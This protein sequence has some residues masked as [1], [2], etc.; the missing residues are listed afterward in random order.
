[1]GVSVVREQ[2]AIITAEGA[3]GGF[4]VTSGR[5]THEAI[6]FAVGKPIVLIDGEQLSK[7][8]ASVS[9]T[10]QPQSH[11][12]FEA[13]RREPAM[14]ATPACPVCKSAMVLRQAKQGSRAGES[15]WG[16]R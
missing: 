12:G 9:K 13:E 1:M 11:S 16:C 6:E 15:F 14:A 7:A 3:A 10:A 5:F 2:F 8:V 4:V